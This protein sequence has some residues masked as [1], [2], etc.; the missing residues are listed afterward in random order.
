MDK[1]KEYKINNI[2]IHKPLIDFNKS[3]LQNKYII[4]NMADKDTYKSEINDP[5]K[6]L[7]EIIIEFKY[8]RL[9]VFLVRKCI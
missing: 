9:G 2:N 7:N 1:V 6:I 3:I 5:K 4:I 8:F